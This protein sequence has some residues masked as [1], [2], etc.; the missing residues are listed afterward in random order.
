LTPALRLLLALC[1]LLATACR[2]AAAPVSPTLARHGLPLSFDLSPEQAER[3]LREAGWTVDPSQTATGI[4]AAAPGQ[5]FGE[6][7][8]TWVHATRDGW[9]ANADF[10]WSRLRR[11]DFASAPLPSEAAVTAMLAEIRARLGEPSWC[12]PPGAGLPI[13]R[14]ELPA[15]I[16]VRL[17]GQAGAWKLVETWQPPA[18]LPPSPAETAPAR[19]GCPH[20]GPPGQGSPCHYPLGFEACT[21]PQACPDMHATPRTVACSCKPEGKW[22]CMRL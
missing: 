20:V 16:V 2:G 19:S 17:E 5:P 6:V 15:D 21:Y 22:S 10:A 18:P 3:A 14:W 1:L 4:F 7:E 12:Q 8:S 11:F 13:A 9:H